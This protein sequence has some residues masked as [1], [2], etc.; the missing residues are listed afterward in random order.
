MT[1][2]VPHDHKAVGL[3]LASVPYDNVTLSITR[4]D[5]F[6]MTIIFLLGEKRKFQ[7]VQPGAQLS[8]I[9]IFV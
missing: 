9:Y 2:Q 8:I 5:G 4:N 7:L 6:I 3:N 1:E